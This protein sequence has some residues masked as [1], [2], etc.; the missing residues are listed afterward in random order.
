MMGDRPTTPTTILYNR[1]QKTAL[2]KLSNK[3]KNE[4]NKKSEPAG[5]V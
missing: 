1:S 3:T 2:L 4:L 5:G